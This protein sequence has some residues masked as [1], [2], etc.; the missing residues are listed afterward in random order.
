MVTSFEQVIQSV[1]ERHGGWARQEQKAVTPLA[2]EAIRNVPDD[3]WLSAMSKC[4]FQV[5]FNWDL[6]EKKW[7]H[8][9]DTFHQF[10][11]ARLVMQSDEDIDNL[12]SVDG[13]V[14]NYAKLK[15][16]RD[17]A[18]FLQRI[19]SEYL[20]VGIYFSTWETEHYVDNLRYLQKHAHAS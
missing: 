8:F 11:I 20:G 14:K 10:K 16:I 18:Y 4:I 2:A 12:M 13:I 6:I 7:P 9:E 19:T 5:G 1:C 3:R 15:S 17:N